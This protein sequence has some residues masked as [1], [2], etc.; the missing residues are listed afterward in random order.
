MKNILLFILLISFGIGF[1]QKKIEYLKNSDNI[2]LSNISME[3]AQ[4]L[5]I[6]MKR[7]PLF[8]M[9]DCN[10]CEDRANAIA[11]IL[12]KRGYTVAK[13][14]LFGEGKISLSNEIYLLKSQKC[15]TWGYHVAIGLQV[16]IDNK[17]E[18]VILDP[19]TQ[20]KA[21]LLENWALPLIQ[22]NRTGFLI[23]KDYSFYTYPVLN[24]KF[25]ANSVW[26]SKDV[27]LSKTA[28]GLCGIKP[29]NCDK[30][31]NYSKISKK[32]AELKNYK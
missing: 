20:D 1:S 25:Q 23:I 16:I 13:F 32:L 18:T 8:N 22:E 6:E 2:T 17:Q 12:T 15:G 3:K 10:N 7:A 30:R 21:V 11:Y 5:F 9:K 31:R 28:C 24:D 4:E 26:I 27:E 19:A 14:W 29:R